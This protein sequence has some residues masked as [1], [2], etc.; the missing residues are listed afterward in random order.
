MFEIVKALFIKD[1]IEAGIVLGVSAL[2]LAGLGIYI[3]YLKAV[4]R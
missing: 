4:K 3:L 2:I 1:A